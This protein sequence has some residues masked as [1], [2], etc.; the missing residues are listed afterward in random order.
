M[1]ESAQPRLRNHCAMS[2]T[3]AGIKIVTKAIVEGI[4]KF[5]HSA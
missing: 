4:E 2:A 5:I 1:K 3:A